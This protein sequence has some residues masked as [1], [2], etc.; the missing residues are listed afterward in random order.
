MK[1]PRKISGSD[2]KGREFSASH[3]SPGSKAKMLER[4]A[5]SIRQ[6]MEHMP[7]KER[8]RNPPVIQPDFRLTD[9]PQNKTILQAEHL[10]F[11]YPNG[12][13][14]FRDAG[15]H[16]SRNS[17]AALLGPN[18]SGK[19]TLLRLIQSGDLAKAPPKA[20]LGFFRQDLSDLEADK[21]VL[22]NAMSTS[23][24]KE[25]VVRGVLARLLFSARDL[26][27]PA[28]VLSGGERIRLSFAKLFVSAANVLILDEPTNYLDIPSAEALEQMFAAYEGTMLFASHDEAFIRAVATERWLIRDHKILSLPMQP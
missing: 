21:S 9:P 19:T 25:A 1:K 11:S 5:Q 27:K 24:Q 4:S 8:P 26:S 23:V 6:R 16:L 7:V 13:E 3:R 12:K 22:Q 2:A 18:G 15:F 20:R 14:I 17:R 10:Y 28:R